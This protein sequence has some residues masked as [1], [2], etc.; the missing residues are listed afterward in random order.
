M[1]LN[2][3]SFLLGCVVL[4][5]ATA[6]QAQDNSILN[7]FIDDARQQLSAN[8]GDYKLTQFYSKT[9]E[10]YSYL[11][12]TFDKSVVTDVTS[13]QSRL[14]NLAELTDKEGGFELGFL[15]ISYKNNH[16]SEAS[17]KAILQSTNR[18]LKGTKVFIGYTALHC[19]NN[20]F[21]ISSPA[22]VSKEIKSYFSHLKTRE[23]QCN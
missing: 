20:V 17:F 23:N 7:T 4:S 12:K 21:I 5:L 18:N 1:K 15:Q 10:D 19:D 13:M 22:V 3:V 11:K 6:C 8:W 9:A 2:R 16:D 14:I